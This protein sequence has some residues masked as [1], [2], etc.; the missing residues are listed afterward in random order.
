MAGMNLLN[1]GLGI[2]LLNAFKRERSLLK[3]S[4][5]HGE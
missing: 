3:D 4:N 2:D 1:V 5:N